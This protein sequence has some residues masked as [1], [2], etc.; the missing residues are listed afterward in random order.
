MNLAALHAATGNEVHELHD[1]REAFR[2]LRKPQSEAQ[3]QLQLHAEPF[4]SGAIPITAT[5]RVMKISE[6]DAHLVHKGHAKSG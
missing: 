6:A 5:G 1:A 2:L 4:A 3:A